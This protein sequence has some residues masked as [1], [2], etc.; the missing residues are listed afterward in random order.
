MK[1]EFNK[2]CFYPLSL[3]LKVNLSDEDFSFANLDPDFSE[4]LEKTTPEE[5]VLINFTDVDV[6]ICCDNA[7]KLMRILQEV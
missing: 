1:P 7:G 6:Y 4:E 5:I 3:L 2:F